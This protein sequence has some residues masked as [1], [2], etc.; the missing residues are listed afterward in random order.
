MVCD[1]DVK[2]RPGRKQGLKEGWEETMRTVDGLIDQK[3]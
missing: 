3:A 1:E 2:A